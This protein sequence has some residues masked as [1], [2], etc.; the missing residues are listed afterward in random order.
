MNKLDIKSKFYLVFL[1]GGILFFTFL[2]ENIFLEI[3][4][5]LKGDGLNKAYFYWFY[6]FFKSKSEYL[7]QIK[8]GLTF[9][10]ILSISLFTVT[11]L[12]LMYGKKIGIFITKI[13][14]AYFLL[15]IIFYLILKLTKTYEDGYFIARKLIG[16]VQTPL[17]YFILSSVIYLYQKEKTK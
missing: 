8:W 7:I 2:R 13:F 1:V 9:F 10:F 12:F 11:S 17:P 15:I 16:I 5:I 4:S 3:N 6:D 14:I